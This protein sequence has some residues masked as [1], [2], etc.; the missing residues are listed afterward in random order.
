MPAQSKAQQRF[1]GM[2]H[3]AQKGDMENPSPE[4]EKAADS[5]SDKDAKD[6]ASTKHDGLPE[7]IK[8]FIVN[9]ARGLKTIER[10]YFSVVEEIQNYLEAYK[11]HKGTPNEKKI[12][13][14]LKELGNKKKS[15]SKE[16]DDKISGLYKDVELKADVDE[17]STS[18]AAGPYNTPFAFGKGEDEKTKGKR[19]A[20][21][22][23]YTVVNENRWLDLKRDETRT[24]SQKV[25]HGIRE[26]KNQLAEIERFVNWYNRLRSENNLG[27]NDFF[28]RTNTNIYRIKERIIKIASSIQEIDKAE[29]EDNIEEVEGKKP[30]ALDKYV[31]TATPKG[32]AKT[33]D[34]RTITRPAPKNSAQAQLKSLTKMDKYQ[35]VRLKKA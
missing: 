15:L 5:M 27:K 4:V 25:S 24:P 13:S 20:D 7:K 19:Q 12:V 17:M 28:K 18:A 32:A 10:E 34:R 9:E 22:T 35:S 26:V 1:M 2:V 21:L 33:A 16:M 8:E 29:S 31:V 30:M 3:S 23:G 14:K 6:F 11:K